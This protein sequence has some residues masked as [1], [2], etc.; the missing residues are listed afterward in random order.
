MSN[1]IHTKFLTQ[2]QLLLRRGSVDIVLMNSATENYLRIGG[3]NIESIIDSTQA[4]NLQG[5]PGIPPIC[6]FLH[7]RLLPTRLNM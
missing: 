1:S 5:P 7:E 4:P 6:K 2:L 3:I